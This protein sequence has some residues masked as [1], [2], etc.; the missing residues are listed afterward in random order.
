MG[1][2]FIKVNGK[3]FNEALRLA[4]ERGGWTISDICMMLDRSANFFNR[5]KETNSLRKS[6]FERACKI[7]RLNPEDYLIK[8]EKETRE[9]SSSDNKYDEDIIVSL[10]SIYNLINKLYSEQ[11]VTNEILRNHLTLMKEINSHSKK[12]E[13]NLIQI[14]LNTKEGGY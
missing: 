5:C 1:E 7:T 9:S 10:N 6:E 8:E 11:K 4:A 13:D 3:R 14:K 12:A 2:E